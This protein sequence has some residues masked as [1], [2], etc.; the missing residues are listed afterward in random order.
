MT[1]KGG[2][3][4]QQ[5]GIGG[6]DFLHAVFAWRSWNSERRIRKMFAPSI[7]RRDLTK[8]LKRGIRVS[9]DG[10][11]LLVD[12]PSTEDHWNQKLFGHGIYTCRRWLQFHLQRIVEEFYQ[13][14]Q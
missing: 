2:D 10:T 9:Q 6:T 7:R 11:T 5:L 4:V 14:A 12:Y 3:Y 13:A 8:N 1:A